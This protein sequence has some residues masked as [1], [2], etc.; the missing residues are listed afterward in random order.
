MKKYNVIAKEW[1]DVAYGNS[2]FSA[3]IIDADGVVVA[4]LEFQYGY[5]DYYLDVA[6]D[7]LAKNVEL[8]TLGYA[9]KRFSEIFAIT[10][11]QTRCPK[12]DVICWGKSE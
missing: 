1:F 4:R 10:E 3:R 2:Y 12:R 9:S 8:N 5:G 7:W 11:K 6:R